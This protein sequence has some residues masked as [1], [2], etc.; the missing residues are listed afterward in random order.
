MAS[1]PK[2]PIPSIY[3]REEWS[4]DTNQY[5]YIVYLNDYPVFV[6]SQRALAEGGAN[7]FITALAQSEPSAQ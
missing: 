6:S 7:Y 3:L 1:N 4:P 5:L 2:Y